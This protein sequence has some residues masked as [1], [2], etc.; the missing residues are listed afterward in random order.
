MT[1]S[2]QQAT[3]EAHDVAFVPPLPDQLV[4]ISPR[5]LDGRSEGAG[6]RYGDMTESGW[7][8]FAPE[9]EEDVSDFIG[10]HASHLRDTHPEIHRYLA[11]PVGWRFAVPSDEAWFDPEVAETAR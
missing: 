11:L 3:C 4:A 2:E 10:I 1:D 6:V 8:V 7:I 5:V 9:V